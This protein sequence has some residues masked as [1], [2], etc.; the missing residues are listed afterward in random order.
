MSYAE[1]VNFIVC[2][3]ALA[4]SAGIVAIIIAEAVDALR[5]LSA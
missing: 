4:A 5:R 1:T 2:I 3:F